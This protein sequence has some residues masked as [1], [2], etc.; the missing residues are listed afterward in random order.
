MSDHSIEDREELVQARGERHL[1]G[2]MHGE[3]TLVEGPDSCIAPGSYQGG[4]VQCSSHSRPA[5]SDH[6]LSMLLAAVLVERRESN[7]SGDPLMRDGAKL[8]KVG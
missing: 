6:T 5:A 3:K 8:G 7:K 2:L 1:L 4:H